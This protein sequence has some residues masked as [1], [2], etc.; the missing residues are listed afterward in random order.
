[1]VRR[2]D[3]SGNPTA[4]KGSSCNYNRKCPLHRQEGAKQ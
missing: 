3:H 1:V 2:L 4:D